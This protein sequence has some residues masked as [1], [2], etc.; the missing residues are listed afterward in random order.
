MV[1]LHEFMCCFWREEI[2][3]SHVCRGEFKRTTFNRY[4]AYIIHI[5]YIKR[6]PI[7]SIMISIVGVL[8]L[9]VGNITVWSEYIMRILLIIIWLWFLLCPSIC[10]HADSACML[11][12]IAN[13]I[14]LKC[15]YVNRIYRIYYKI[16]LS[17]ART[18]IVSSCSS[19]VPFRG[20]YVNFDTKYPR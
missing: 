15:I 5:I 6:T 7:E 13:T 1:F 18:I 17:K 16:L 11:L 9:H 2:N 3:E 19:V 4:Y 12:S 8:G 10:D 20:Q 14:N